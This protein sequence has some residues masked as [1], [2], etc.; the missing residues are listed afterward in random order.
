[1]KIGGFLNIIKSRWICDTFFG[2]CYNALN[3]L[4]MLK[5][6]NQ[7]NERLKYLN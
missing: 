7:R 3:I 4:L 1:M 5:L 2:W 6:R